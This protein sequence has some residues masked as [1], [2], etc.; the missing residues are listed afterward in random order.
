MGK[1]SGDELIDHLM[2][3][4]PHEYSKPCVGSG[5]AL[6][7]PDNYSMRAGKDSNQCRPFD[8]PTLTHRQVREI[9]EG[10]KWEK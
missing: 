2:D 6:M 1:E 8:K 10:D 9:S 5:V 4:C 3:D 7:F